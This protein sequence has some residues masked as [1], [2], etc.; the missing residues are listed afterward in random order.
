MLR[1]LVFVYGTLKV[2]EPNHHWL[3]N[4]ANGYNR[5]VGTAR[6]VDKF[7]LVIASR[8]NIPYLLNAPGIGKN[9]EGEVYEVD[10]QM[11]AK[12]DIL[13]DHPKYYKREIR[14]VTL[15]ASATNPSS[16]PATNPSS[17]TDSTPP[18]PGTELDVWVYL[19]HSFKPAMLELPMLL[20]Y[21]AKGDHGLEYVASEDD[22]SDPEDI[23]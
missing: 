11:L 5:L 20:S 7:P 14:Q 9:V 4:A 1:C 22:I 10:E 23:M 21:S 15:V 19:L 13:E 17:T 3:S 18:A 16:T 6:T 8:Y 12:L 2:G